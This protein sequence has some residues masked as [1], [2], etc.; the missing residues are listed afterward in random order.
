MKIHW[1][2]GDS[3]S[4]GKFIVKDAP[5]GLGL[6]NFSY[7]FDQAGDIFDVKELS[8]GGHD[9]LPFTKGMEPGVPDVGA[10]HDNSGKAIKERWMANQEGW[11]TKAI[12]DF[13]VGF[14][15]TLK[16]L[17][18]EGIANPWRVS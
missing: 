7:I 14:V 1:S 18:Q 17:V 15:P 5:T 10:P 13:M 9:A 11:V 6:L 3:R 4:Y 12:E 2:P 16:E 8:I